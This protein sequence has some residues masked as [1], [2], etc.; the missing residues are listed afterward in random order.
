MQMC[1]AALSKGTI[2]IQNAMNE[3]TNPKNQPMKNNK[4]PKALGKAI[5]L[6]EKHYVLSLLN[7]IGTSTDSQLPISSSGRQGCT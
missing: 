7:T 5:G 3:T 6:T 4:Y 2:Q 1:N